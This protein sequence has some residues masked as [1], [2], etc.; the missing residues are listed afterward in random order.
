MSTQKPSGAY[1]LGLGLVVLSFAIY[2]FQFFYFGEE[3]FRMDEGSPFFLSHAISV[4]YFIIIFMV[5]LSKIGFKRFHKGD[6]YAYSAALVLFSLSAH[7][8]NASRDFNIFATYTDWMAGLVILMHIAILV[9]PFRKS[10]PEF[11]QYALYFASGVSLVTSTYMT[12][13][14]GPLNFFGLLLSPILGISMVALVPFWFMIH[15]I[16]AIYRIQ[17][18]PHS[19][20]AFWTGVLAPVL[21]LVGF[22]AKWKMVQHNIEQARIEYNTYYADSYPEW[23]ILSQQITDGPFTEMVAMS[24]A[25]SQKTFWDNDGLGVFDDLSYNEFVRHNP[26][27]IIA[28][29]LY[30]ELKFS[31]ETLMKLLESRFDARHMTHRRLWNGT[32]LK[33]TS[34]NNAITVYPEYRIAYLEKT[35]KIKNTSSD[36]G[37]F[38]EAVYS[39]YLPEGS[40]ATSLSLWVNGVEEKSRLTTKG[41]ADKAYRRIVGVERRDPSLLHWQEGNRITVT[42]YPCTPQEERQFKVGFTV[43]MTLDEDELVLNNI[44]FKGPASSSARE[45]TSLEIV[46]KQAGKPDLFWGMRKKEE[47]TYHFSGKYYPSQEM[48]FPAPPLSTIPF[49]F[50]GNSFQVIP[51]QT[52]K[53]PLAPKEIILD[54]NRAWSKREF[55]KVWNLVK[56]QK[57]YVFLP[58]KTQVTEENF[59][60][61]YNRLKINHFSLLPI[62]QIKNPEETLIISHST[63]VG[64]I[65]EDLKNSLFANQLQSYLI[66]NHE[67]LKWFDLGDEPSPIVRS[68]KEFRILNYQQGEI[69]DLKEALEDK[70]FQ[71]EFENPTEIALSH[72]GM[73]IKHLSELSSSTDAPDHLMRLYAYNDLMKMIGKE[74]FNKEKL[75]DNWLRKAEEA[76]V[77]S[78]VS[79]LIV[80]ETIADYE[81]F[82]I[83]KNTNTLGNAS[84][85]NSGSV[86]EPHEWVLI[87]MVGLMVLWQAKKRFLGV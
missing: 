67:K 66:S 73:N 50:N 76:Y 82:N 4:F 77:V 37:P 2:I 42:I 83:K 30:G 51:S 40:I 55:K 62:Y 22:L 1:Y 69:S 60:E 23:V 25:T 52:A 63:H 41:K 43:P 32:D 31:S 44:Y 3:R 15:F 27:A 58:V 33:T 56:D 24:E 86:P 47:N 39:F 8:L 61:I 19:R 49:S 48:R 21:I 20:R 79:S 7:T 16:Q 72:A 85:K 34:I 26:L 65:L 59:D 68:L 84:H 74:Y 6:E 5:H 78:P 18:L 12:L 36:G 11:A 57:V 81:R 53:L 46:G 35:L 75:E 71:S 14:L 80:L 29:M 54:I 17:P 28:N 70:V 9:F 38:Q 45:E 10:L 87:M 64:P 13:F